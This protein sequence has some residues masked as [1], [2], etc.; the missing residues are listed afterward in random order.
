MD[1]MPKARHNLRPG[2]SPERDV[3]VVKL[4]VHM[5]PELYDL[6][7]DE[8]ARR[9]LA[10]YEL[11]TALAAEHFGRP[12]LGFIPKAKRGRKSKRERETLGTR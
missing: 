3:E 5:R 1:T 2:K 6:V 12:E 11:L 9:N 8:A 4:E 7:A 10:R